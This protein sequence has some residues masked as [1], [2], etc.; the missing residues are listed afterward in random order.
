MTFMRAGLRAH[1]R[2]G[3][4]FEFHREPN[5]VAQPLIEH[6]TARVINGNRL[7]P[8]LD[9]QRGKYTAPSE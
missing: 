6:Y 4:L 2:M 7:D 1:K 9:E 5:A 3:E 8:A